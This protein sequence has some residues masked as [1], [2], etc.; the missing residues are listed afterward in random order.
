MPFQKGNTY[1]KFPKPGNGGHNKKEVVDTKKAARELANE[2]IEQNI[3]P[4][5]LNYLRLA[6]SD[7]GATTR[8]FVDKVLPEKPGIQINQQINVNQEFNWNEYQALC[9]TSSGIRAE[10]K[11]VDANSTSESIHSSHTDTE[12]SIVSKP[13]SS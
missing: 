3:K 11:A 8:H 9:V 1:G 13:T 2:F 12:A 10:Q 7:D 5:L 4:V 6:K